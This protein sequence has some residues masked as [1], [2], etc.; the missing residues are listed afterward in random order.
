[1][2]LENAQKSILSQ[3]GNC[4]EWLTGLEKGGYAKI[5]MRIGESMT[6]TLEGKESWPT[7]HLQD[8][9]CLGHS[10]SL[11]YSLINDTF[12]L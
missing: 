3:I 5:K 6:V 4:N 2:V 8:M 1:M 12:D 7:D 10:Y 9:H 11:C